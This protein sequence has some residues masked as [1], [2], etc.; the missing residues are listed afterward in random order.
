MPPINGNLKPAPVVFSFIFKFLGRRE[1]N[2]AIG[3]VI[4]I[5]AAVDVN[6]LWSVGD[7]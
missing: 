7:D 2:S 6:Q 3:L 4:R 1:D 5:I